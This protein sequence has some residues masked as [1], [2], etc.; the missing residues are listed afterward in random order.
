MYVISSVILWE[1]IGVHNMK[2]KFMM[3]NP[4]APHTYYC[5]SLGNKCTECRKESHV[6]RVYA[7]IHACSTFDTKL[8]ENPDLLGLKTSTSTWYTASHCCHCRQL[9][10]LQPQL[11]LI[12]LPIFM[13]DYEE[14]NFGE[15]FVHH[16]R[17]KEEVIQT[18]PKLQTFLLVSN[19]HMQVDDV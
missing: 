8:T 5:T 13:C 4:L 9:F 2:Y 19:H 6:Y 3:E 1:S 16:L 12:D 17:F 11:L 18:S 10:Q 14:R 7:I 15:N